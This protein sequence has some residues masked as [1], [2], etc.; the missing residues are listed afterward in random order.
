MIIS[1]IIRKDLAALFWGCGFLIFLIYSVLGNHLQRILTQHAV[2]PETIDLKLSSKGVFPGE[3]T[4]AFIKANLPSVRIPGFSYIFH[5]TLSWKTRDPVFL[6]ER[7]DTGENRSVLPF[8]PENRGQFQ[9][10]DVR[11][12]L[13]DL[14]GFTRSALYL[15]INENL[16][17]YPR[18]RPGAR[19]SFRQQGGNSTEHMKKQ[20]KKD[21]LLEIR[22]YFPGD[23][24]R[25]LNWKLFAHIG[26][27]YIR[28]GEQ[29]PPPRS[30][31]LFILDTS[32][33]A[34]LPEVLATRYLDELVETA[35][36]TML[37][38]L[39]ENSTSTLMLTLPGHPSVFSIN[40]EGGEALLRLL[41]SV[42][43]NEDG[44]T[45]LPN[46]RDLHAVVFSSPGSRDLESVLEQVKGKNWGLTLLFTSSKFLPS[47][48]TVVRKALRLRDLFILPS[49]GGMAVQNPPSGRSSGPKEEAILQ[50][51]L[52]REEARFK[53]SP[54][55]LTDVRIL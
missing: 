11:L 12:T 42:W 45:V 25:K 54:W 52:L 44:K 30:N 35:C 14:F 36:S 17:V 26:E 10:G 49:T 15:N 48:H 40:R 3:K 23:D 37:Q 28:E 13:Q 2:N 6:I 16:S 51:I 9:S 4:E 34:I 33:S 24:V 50:D 41:A 22:K 43:W 19:V 7:L 20:K 38:F 55:K 31:L 29:T 39:L 8:R 27:L 1:G 46:E 18:L 53:A 47:N 32:R 5:A 21:E